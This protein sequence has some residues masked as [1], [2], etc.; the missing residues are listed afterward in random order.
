MPGWRARRRVVPYRWRGR[1]GA[2]KVILKKAI[3]GLGEARTVVEVADGYARHFLFPR[4]LA[5][6]ATP[7]ALARLRREAE[8]ARVQAE[9][10]LARAREAAGAVR[11]RR[12]VV[13]APAGE[14]GRLFGA[15]TPS[16]VAAALREQLGVE[17]D[18]RQVEMPSPVKTLGEH[19]LALRFPPEVGPVRF[20]LAVLPEEGS[21][22]SGA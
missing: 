2:L 13:R 10:E 11:G 16:Q 4:G 1:S 6:E 17:V 22:G 15:V 8:K 9:L 5:E 3:K 7:E 21:G 20:T 19:Q 18:K 14:R 12:I